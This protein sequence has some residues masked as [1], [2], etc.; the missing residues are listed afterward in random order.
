[1]I[2]DFTEQWGHSSSLHKEKLQAY[3]MNEIRDKLCEQ[4]SAYKAYRNHGNMYAHK[5]Y[6]NLL[7]MLV[8]AARFRNHHYHAERLQI[9]FYQKSR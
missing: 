9:Q 5:C 8:K 1:M 7:I 2:S 4:A 3:C 6:H